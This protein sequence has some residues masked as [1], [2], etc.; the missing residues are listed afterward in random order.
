LNT[1]YLAVTV[2]SEPDKSADICAIRIL[3]ERR[4]AGRKRTTGVPEKTTQTILT[5]VKVTE[6]QKKS[7][8]IKVC[9][10]EETFRV[11]T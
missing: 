5:H 8:C 6:S 9:E 10:Q 11:C 2:Y 4:E 7:V 1:Q 3:N